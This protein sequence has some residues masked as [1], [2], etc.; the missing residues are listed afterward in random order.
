M[1]TEVFKRE[2]TCPGAQVKWHHGVHEVREV[3]ERFCKRHE[4]AKADM[5]IYGIA[6]RSWNNSPAESGYASL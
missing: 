2:L 4:G 6:N 1:Y 5:T 3:S